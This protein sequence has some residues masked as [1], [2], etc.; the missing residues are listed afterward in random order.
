MCSL[1]WSSPQFQCFTNNLE[2]KNFLRH[3]T[4]P[5]CLERHTRLPRR[6]EQKPQKE[7]VFILTSTAR[8][9][10]TKQNTHTLSLLQRKAQE[11]DTQHSRCY[12]GKPK[13]HTHTFNTAPG[14]CAHLFSPLPKAEQ[15]AFSTGS[16]RTCTSTLTNTQRTNTCRNPGTPALASKNTLSPSDQRGQ[17]FPRG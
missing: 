2:E 12:R 11:A 8:N 13:K 4:E 17:P 14:K 3:E 6:E 15:R 7:Q 1:T 9:K 5:C 10:N 16:G